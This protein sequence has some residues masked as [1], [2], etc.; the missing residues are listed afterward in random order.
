MKKQI[1]L[2]TLAILGVLLCACEDAKPAETTAEAPVTTAPVETT[3]TAT[4]TCSTSDAN[5]S[6]ELSG[7]ATLDASAIIETGIKSYAYRDYAITERV[8]TYKKDDNTFF[9]SYPQIE[10]AVDKET[11][12]V[13]NQKIKESFFLGITESELKL[14]SGKS[15]MDV[16]Y[17]ITYQSGSYVSLVYYYNNCFINNGSPVS[18]WGA[19]TIELGLPC[20]ARADAFLL[21]TEDLLDAVQSADMRCD[22]MIAKH[23]QTIEELSE[24]L[25]SFGLK[26]SSLRKYFLTQDYV[27]I[28]LECGNGSFAPVGL[29]IASVFPFYTS[30]STVLLQSNKKSCKFENYIVTEHSFVLDNTGD[31]GRNFSYFSVHYPQIEVKNKPEFSAMINQK[32]YEAFF[33][34]MTEED[35]CSAEGAS[36][37]DV[38]YAITYADERYLSI[39]YYGEDCSINASYIS[40]M[41]EGITLDLFEC[42]ELSLKDFSVTVADLITATQKGNF[43]GNRRFADNYWSFP[44]VIEAVKAFESDITSPSRFFFSK[45]AVYL[46]IPCNRFCDAPLRIP[47]TVL[48]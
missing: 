10:G 47:F 6:T 35:F 15:H 42:K 40:D 19:F 29:P 9:I 18:G 23:Y 44:L 36:W 41:W 32:I 38:N 13:L 39:G 16:S 14:S 12:K 20:E 34:G 8:F 48:K 31:D 37:I 26:S 27:Y 3:A 5:I 33:F 46:S 4:T 43:C 24:A 11:L 22:P 1:L 45:D 21:T 17:A 7:A 30:D 28:L 2:C 25:K